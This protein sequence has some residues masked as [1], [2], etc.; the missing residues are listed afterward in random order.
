M[1]EENINEQVIGGYSL[2]EIIEGTINNKQKYQSILY[3]HFYKK[4]FVVV[5][6]YTKNKFDTEDILQDSFLKLYANIH[7]YGFKGS[8]EGWFRRMIV[9]N[10]LDFIKAKKKNKLYYTIDDDDDY[11]TLEISEPSKRVHMPEKFELVDLNTIKI[12]EIKQAIVNLSP[13]YKKAFNLYV[14]SG[15]THKEIAEQLNIS[16]STSKTNLF[17]AKKKIKELISV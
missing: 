6:P 15:Y 7:K 1:K 9:L 5:F 16:V 11:S 8:F 10:S 4:M 13:A 2:V 17:K 14:I 12:D 3:K